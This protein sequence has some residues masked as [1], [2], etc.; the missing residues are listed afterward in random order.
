M[1]GLNSSLTKPAEIQ[2]QYVAQGCFT[3]RKHIEIGR[4]IEA[5]TPKSKEKCKI[6]H[7][8]RNNSRHQY[9]LETIS[10]KTSLM[11]KKLMAVVEIKL[12]VSQQ[13]ALA[14]KANS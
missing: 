7:L 14:V 2:N 4:Q 13:C 5:R 9:A 6:L 8:Q 11:R 12:N 1:M 3:Q 10:W